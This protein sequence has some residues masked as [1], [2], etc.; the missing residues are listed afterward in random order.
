VLSQSGAWDF[1]GRETTAV[2]L[3]RDGPVAPIRIWMDA[4]RYETLFEPNEAM[5]DLLERR[6][7]DVTY[8][9]YAAG[10]NFTAWMEELLVGLPAL[11]PPGERA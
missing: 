10:H 7:Y 6:G 5:A 1:D 3:V 11:L 9:R 4:G 2:P 8:R